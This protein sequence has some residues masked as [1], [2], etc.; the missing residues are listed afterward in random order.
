LVFKIVALPISIRL[1]ETL[2]SQ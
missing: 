2:K 1:E